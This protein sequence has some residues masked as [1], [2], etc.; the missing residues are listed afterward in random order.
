MFSTTEQ[1]PNV[2]HKRACDSV[3][4]VHGRGLPVLAVVFRFT[5]RLT[6]WL[7][8]CSAGPPFRCSSPL[9]N[10]SNV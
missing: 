6:L 1:P 8:K 4:R 5:W 9:H 3:V 10:K 7:G 2:Q